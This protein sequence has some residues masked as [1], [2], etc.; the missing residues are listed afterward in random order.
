MNILVTGGAGYLG[1]ILVSTLLNHGHRVHVLDNFRHG[2][3]SLNG[4]CSNA[5]LAVTVGDCRKEVDLAPLLAKADVV[6][7]L[8]AIVGMPACATDP[9]AAHSTNVT[10]VAHICRLAS[11]EQRIIIP[12]T[13]SGYGI[14]ERDKECTEDSPLRPISLYGK[15]KVEA[16]RIVFVRGNAISLRFA[17][18]FGMSPRMRLDLLVND[19]VRRA[20]VDGSVVLFEGSFRRNYL[21]VR[22]AAAAFLHAIANFEE[23][24]GRP[25]N[26]GLSDANLSKRDLCE[27][28]E[29]RVPGF[30]IMEAPVGKDVD[31]RDYVVSNARIEA[32][33][34][35]PK[36]SLDDGICELIKGIP[37]LRGGAYGNL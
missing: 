18:L 21:H 23:M 10:A 32:T 17:T 9:T 27:R 20:M 24:K 15:T 14:G 4:L 33:G 8:A 30:T 31:Q 7:P 28:I 35:R 1:S 12:I 26:V 2:V 3:A 6:I 22:D 5:H 11:A 19:F 34:Y 16:E 25:Y 37:M 13:N 29:R 36:L